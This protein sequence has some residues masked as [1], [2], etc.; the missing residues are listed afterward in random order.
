MI[1]LVSFFFLFIVGYSHASY[2][3][4]IG[5]SLIVGS[6]EKLRQILNVRT[7]IDAKV[8]R[9][10]HEAFEI[11]Y[12]LANNNALGDIVVINLTNNSEVSYETFERLLNYLNSRGKTVILVNTHVPRSWKNQNNQTL[13]QLVKDRRDFYLLDWNDIFKRFCRNTTCL[14][15]DQVH[16][17]E[18][19]SYIYAYSI[20]YAVQKVIKQRYLYA[21]GK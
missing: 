17:T 2:V 4:I 12:D 10:F 5:D 21:K 6:S 15:K 3:S 20:A 9:H 18:D 8:G 1:F 11:I 7:I 19:G 14:R 16:L 13:L